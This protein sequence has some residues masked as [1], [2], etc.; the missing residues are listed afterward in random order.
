MN[1]PA[2]YWQPEADAVRCELCPHRCRLAPGK[3]GRCLGRR[4]IGGALVAA[5]YGNVVTAAMDPIEKK[6]LYHFHPGSDI[7]SVATYGCN[8]SCPFCQ[9][10]ELSQQEQPGR[11]VPPEELVEL[12]RARGGI[13]VAFTYSE[14]LVWYE[15]LLDACPALRA[16]GLRTVLVTNGMLNPEPLAELLPL[17]D[18]MNLDL[19]SI[20]P[21]FY[22]DYVRGDLDT[23]RHTLAAASRR[24][25]LEVTNLLIPGRN[26]T[27][28]EIEELARF[29]AGLG[30]AIPLHITR[31]FPRGRATE[32]ATP[33]SSLVRAGEIARQKLDYVYLGNLGV[34][35]RWRDTFCPQCGRLQVERAG[36]RG[37]V[38]GVRAGACCGCGR[39]ADLV[40]P[41][42]ES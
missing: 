31:Y 14:P 30:R 39:G 40:L 36:S 23:V 28:P 19:K 10:R 33:E 25:H 2:R 27:E 17:I 7:L 1:H 3:A 21:E 26:D 37:R 8:L 12:A 34:D 15:Y 9:N 4:N 42:S 20:R 16:A 18:A 11:F 5:S 6:P 38:V 41:E 35:P 13:G 22:R 29:L 32:P 24:C